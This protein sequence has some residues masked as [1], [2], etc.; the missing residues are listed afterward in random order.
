MRAEPEESEG[1]RPQAPATVRVECR[2]ANGSLAHK[3]GSGAEPQ[4][5]AGQRPAREI[6]GYFT[7][8]ITIFFST[9]M[10]VV[11][12]T[13]STCCCCCCRCR[14]LRAHALLGRSPAHTSTVLATFRARALPCC[15]LTNKIQASGPGHSHIHSPSA[16]PS[17]ISFSLGPRSE[18]SIRSS[19]NVWIA[20][21]HDGRL[22]RLCICA[23][24]HL[25][26][27]HVRNVTVGHMIHRSD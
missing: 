18:L 4:R 1:L 23:G 14:A 7:L 27:A 24:L 2:Y 11:Y 6:F 22:C 3:F 26:T 5:G 13:L 17:S 9:I 16:S 8:E 12:S 15:R 10:T 21:G 19:K 20:C 25:S